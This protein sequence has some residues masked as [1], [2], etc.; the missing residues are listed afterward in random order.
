M[1]SKEQPERNPQSMIL[2]ESLQEALLADQEID[3]GKI[4]SKSVQTDEP[5][6]DAE[7]GELLKKAQDDF[8]DEDDPLNK[9]VSVMPS[10]NLRN[11][12]SRYDQAEAEQASLKLQVKDLLEE[13]ARLK[14][15]VKTITASYMKETEWRRR[16][17]RQLLD[18]Q[19]LVRQMEGIAAK[20]TSQRVI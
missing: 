5:P 18:W 13:N 4:Q 10:F 6:F 17:T 11:E 1:E 16:F 15:A 7:L 8:N 3:S 12:L 14:E 20:I 19:A 9:A 2:D